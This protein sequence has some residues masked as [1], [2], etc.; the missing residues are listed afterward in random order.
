MYDPEIIYIEGAKMFLA[1]PLS[2][3]CVNESP[4]DDDEEF[5]VQLLLAMSD[6]AANTLRE[7]T[8]KDQLCQDLIEVI[9][10]GWPKNKT[11]L[12][13]SLQQF[14]NYRD[15]L[16]HNDGIIVKS[17]KIFIPQAMRIRVLGDI[18]K[19]HFGIEKS[20]RRARQTV[21]WPQMNKNIIDTISKCVT[22]QVHQPSKQKKPLLNKEVPTLPFEIVALDL[23]Q[24]KNNDYISV[25]DSYSGLISMA[26]L[27][28]QTS[29]AVID[30]IRS[31][32][33]THGIP[34][35]IESDN[36][37]QLG[38]FEFKQFAKEWKFDCRTSSPYHPSGNGL[39]ESGVKRSKNIIKKCAHDGSDI[40]LA[41]LNYHNS[42]RGNIGSP[43]QR[44]YNR[45]LRTL[46]PATKDNLKPRIIDD[47]SKNLTRM[48][49][50]QKCFA[51]KH[52]K[53]SGE[54]MK[55]GDQVLHQVSRRNW[56][57]A[58]IIEVLNS[59]SMKIR[60]RRGKVYRRNTIHLRKTEADVPTDIR[61]TA[62]PNNKEVHD[63]VIDN[64]IVHSEQM[65]SDEV[66]QSAGGQ[67]PSP[68]CTNQSS[69][70]HQQYRTRSGRSIK[71]PDRL[72]L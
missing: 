32:F 10:S 44:I 70:T 37:P 72:D 8:A 45:S 64:P 7:M 66:D 50:K 51:D 22:C 23:F 63:E 28:N 16:S 42:P 47:V 14:W 68:D 19:A 38:S 25:T 49:E 20:I 60:D 69:S 56:K 59:R 9:T 13:V 41:L 12:N 21:F 3:D 27:P 48:R 18:H 52:R 58:E 29:K 54:N 5:E 31:V 1:D 43:A 39:A 71:R 35:V 24:L 4:T 46:L 62:L 40:Y 67:S 33:A 17:E 2:R 34:R 36:G 26:Q 11:D 61:Q 30:F 15:E 65:Q 57:P 53:P 55:I 6:D